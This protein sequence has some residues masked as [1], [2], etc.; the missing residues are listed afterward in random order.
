MKTSKHY[1]TDGI[2]TIKLKDGAPVPESFHRG[3]TFNHKT[4]NKGLKVATDERV[5]KNHESATKARIASGNYVSWNKGLTKENCESLKRVSEKVSKAR[6]GK[7]P[8][9]KGIPM[10]DEAKMKLSNSNKGKTAWNKGL[11]KDTDTRLIG[12]SLKQRG[13]KDYVLDW[14]KAKQKEYETKKLNKS[15][16]TS[17]PEK[18]LYEQLC[19]KYGKG[20]VLHPYRCSEYKHNCD[21]YIVSEKLFIEL[22]Y[23]WAH[24][25]KPYNPNDEDCINLLNKWKEKARDHV[26]YRYAIDYWT[27][28]DVQKLKDFRDNKLNFLIIYPNLTIDK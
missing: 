27:N 18:E 9:N 15:F 10:S 7:S 3:R 13:H 4:W 24:G 14:N 23:H 1:Y 5:R 21:F 11:T 6:K 12:T 17:K 26:Q 25:G 28:K 2:T 19:L 16:N 20:N 8:W 22:N